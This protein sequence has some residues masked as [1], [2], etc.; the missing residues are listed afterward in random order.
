MSSA[1]PHIVE[2]TTATF[3]RDVLDR[4]KDVPVLVDFWASWCQPC[5]MLTPL[6]EKLAREYAGGFVLV[7][8]DTERL[9]DIAGALGVQ[10]IPT[11]FAFKDGEVVDGFIG[12]Q[13]E[14]VIR[15]IIDRL[16]PS[17]ADRLIR[18][19]KE[20]ETTDPKAA[21]SSYRAALKLV[22]DS[23]PARIGLARLG[24]AR[25]KVD[26]ARALVAELEARGYLEPEAETLKAEL[27]LA[28][29]A[30]SSVSVDAA[31]TTSAAAPND[32]SLRFQLAEALA[33]SHQY[34]EALALCLDLVER[35]RKGV[36]EDARKTMLTI[37]QVL[38]PDSALAN[39]Y[40]RRLSLAL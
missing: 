26:E 19:A 8:A 30:R 24:L 27:A 7:K 36:G 11:V 16:L 22:P 38:P 35:D 15:E 5:R 34:E 31:R 23:L 39:D 3:E 21:E 2:T 33:T 4:S 14:K 20:Q 37:F 10:S 9:P 6:L 32:L 28:E 13:S 25:K 17:P 18:A 1:S 40:R 29:Q 12:V